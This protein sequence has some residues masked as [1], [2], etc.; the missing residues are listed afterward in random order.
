MSGIFDNLELWYRMN[1]NADSTVVLDSS[2]NGHHGTSV[3]NTNLMRTAGKICWALKFD[4]VDDFINAGHH[5]SDVLSNDCTINIL[6]KV[7]QRNGQQL[8]LFISDGDLNRFF[9]RITEQA[10][11]QMWDINYLAF[12]CG[13]VDPYYPGNFYTLTGGNWAMITVV[14]K[15]H[16]NPDKRVEAK[17]YLNAVENTYGTQEVGDMSGFSSANNL[18]IGRAIPTYFDGS[19]DDVMIFNKALTDEEVLWLYNK[20][21]KASAGEAAGQAQSRL[22]A[23]FYAEPDTI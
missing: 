5:F 3:R 16:S 23:E 14:L 8:L 15:Q 18:L 22:T 4:G 17:L 12:S 1:D 2:G 21:N 10:E 6:C 9:I 19:I 11:G 13:T 7:P 20:L